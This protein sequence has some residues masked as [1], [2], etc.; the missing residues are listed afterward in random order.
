[1]TTPSPTWTPT[2]KWHLICLSVCLVGVLISFGTLCFVSTHLPA[3]YQP[4]TPM[5]GTTPWN[6]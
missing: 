6:N 1:M 4:R 5:Q 3:P 2:L